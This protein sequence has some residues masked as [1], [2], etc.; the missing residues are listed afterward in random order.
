MRERERGR[1]RE[2]ERE[3]DRQR[4]RERER[5]R[6]RVRCSWRDGRKRKKFFLV[7]GCIPT[8][9][10]SQLGIEKTVNI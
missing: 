5:E 3:T 4:E 6:E 10:I 9:T 1:E 7:A 2:R 8:L